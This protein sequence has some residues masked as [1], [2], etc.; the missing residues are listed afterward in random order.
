M[1]SSK[2][3]ISKPV[4]LAYFGKSRHTS[5]CF[6]P[7]AALGCIALPISYCFHLFKVRHECD[8]K[9]GIGGGYRNGKGWM[10]FDFRA[11]HCYLSAGV[12]TARDF[13]ERFQKEKHG[14]SLW[15]SAGR[16]WVLVLGIL[17]IALLGLVYRV[18]LGD[19]KISSRFDSSRWN[20]KSQAWPAENKLS[21]DS[22]RIHFDALP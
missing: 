5:V 15:C 20:P 14:S 13:V 6:S 11:S 3:T 17:T 1:C 12:A 10:L 4:I 22:A 9:T 16:F 19:F 7:A 2:R 21:S 8:E 18:H